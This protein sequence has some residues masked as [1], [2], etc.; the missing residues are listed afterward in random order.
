MASPKPL[1]MYFPAAG[2]GELS[3][4]ISAAG[5]V[6][7]DDCFP[8]LSWKKEVGFFKQMPCIKH[9]NF[10]IPQTAACEKYLAAISPNFKDLTPQEVALDCMFAATLEDMR[11][12][13][14]KVTFGSPEAKKAACETIPIHLDKF[15]P[16]IE[17][18]TPA[19]GFVQGKD[20]PTVADMVL[21][22]FAEAAGPFQD[23]IELAGNYDWAV[24]FPKIKA[25]VT[26]TKCFKA[27][28]QYLRKTKSL[29]AKI[30]KC[31]IASLVAKSVGNTLTA[32][33]FRG[34]SLNRGAQPPPAGPPRSAI[35]FVAEAPELI[36]FPFAGRG[37]LARLICAAGGVQ[38]QNT[39][40]PS[41]FK[42]SVGLFGSLPILT[43]GGM[44]I[45]QSGAIESYLA[46][47]APKFRELT[48]QQRAYDDFFAATK[49]DIL[50]SMMPLVIGDGA[51]M[52]SGRQ[53][54]A[55]VLTPQ[56]TAPETVPKVLE[57]F[58]TVIEALVPSSGFVQGLAF[59]TTADLVL[60]LVTEAEMPFK[61][62]I[63]LA[64]GYDWQSKFP[65]IKANIDRT[66]QAPGVKEYLSTSTSMSAS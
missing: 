1:F 31:F 43:H 50:A 44:T 47:I 18:L 56:N 61:A 64:G 26:R 21:L 13:C 24:L 15:L 19:D 32:G 45:C 2:R 39:P 25:N 51:K 40:A 49:E 66:K 62:A 16:V 55:D 7:I 9:G 37:E 3:R 11:G 52:S 17:R 48:P 60:L 30:N 38:L 41:D 34:F 27:V 54:I 5:G 20:F 53:S 57:K 59:P 46:L 10:S 33:V 12:G 22:N 23:S 6:E 8:G 4:L 58:L 28:A 65:N 42:T 35:P 29:K 63:D 36:Y 14:Y